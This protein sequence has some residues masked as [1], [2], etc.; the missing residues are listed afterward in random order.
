MWIKGVG[1]RTNVWA[2]ARAMMLPE[3]PRTLQLAVSEKPIID[4]IKHIYKCKNFL[5]QGCSPGGICF[6]CCQLSSLSQKLIGSMRRKAA[7]FVAAGQLHHRSHRCAVNISAPCDVGSADG[8]FYGMNLAAFVVK[9]T[10]A[11]RVWLPHWRL[12]VGYP[13][14]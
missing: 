4:T 1:G 2:T 8:S 13:W 12:R 5:E 3:G 11:H 7:R 14:V 6:Y 9:A 10:S